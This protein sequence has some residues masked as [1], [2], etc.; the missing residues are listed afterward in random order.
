MLQTQPNSP[1]TASPFWGLLL[2]DHDIPIDGKRISRL[3]HNG[4]K[5]LQPGQDDGKPVGI[6]STVRAHTVKEWCPFT[7]RW[8]LFSFALIVKWALVRHP[9]WT[10]AYRER[11]CRKAFA[12]LYR[13]DAFQTNGYGSDTCHDWINGSNPKKED[14][15]M[16]PVFTAGNIVRVLGAAERI[17]GVLRYPV[18]CLD[19]RQPPPDPNTFDWDTRPQYIQWATIETR[20]LKGEDDREVRPFDFQDISGMPFFILASDANVAWIDVTRIRP[21]TN[22]DNNNP[23]G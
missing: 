6:P 10:V 21:V 23:Y 16:F 15:R 8:Q 1:E 11:L 18:R 13:N 22:W 2:H 9:E 4:F 7:L 20:I 17:G 3:E 5:L 12:Q 14:M 19:G